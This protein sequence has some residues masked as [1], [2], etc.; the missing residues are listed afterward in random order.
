MELKKATDIVYFN[1]FDPRNV[2]ARSSTLAVV[3]RSPGRKVNV[4]KPTFDYGRRDQFAPS[5]FNLVE[6]GTIEDVESYVRQ[7]FQKKTAL[8]F[9][10][11]EEFIGK[12]P[13]TIKYIKTR[14]TQL[15]YVS[16]I[17]WR[18]LLR[19]TGH[20]LISRSNY[21]W[22]KS[23]NQEASGGMSI[24][25][26][27]PVAAYFGMGGEHVK[28]KKN[29]QGRIVKYKQ[30]MPD[31]RYREFSPRN[32]VHFYA[33]KKDGFAFGTPQIV[34]TK[35]DIRTLR[36]IEENVELLIY[37]TLFPIFQYQVGTELKPSGDIKLS[38]GTVISEVD[39]VREQIR[40]MP[41]EGGIVTPERHKLE[42]IGAEGKALKAREYLD[43]FKAR[44]FSGLGVSS[45]DMGEG[46]TANRSTSDTMSKT[47]I[48]SVKDFQSILEDFINSYILKE[49]LL[50]STFDFDV[51][52]PENIVSFKFKEIDIEQQMKKN[53]NAQVLYNGNVIDIDEARE[54][55]GKEPMTEDQEKK[56]FSNRVSIPELLVQI[57]GQL[58]IAQSR[59]SAASNQASNQNA[60]TN[61]HGKNT[62]PQKSKLD[63]FRVVDSY[64]GD[65][66]RSLKMDIS[67]HIKKEII[68]KNWINTLVGLSQDNIL[69][70]YRKIIS[71]EFLMGLRDS[72]LEADKMKDV[73]S[74]EFPIVDSNLTLYVNK[75]HRDIKGK[76][77][78]AID[79]NTALGRPNKEI[80]EEARKEI[81]TIRYRA[82]FI[83]KT[84]RARAYNYGK[85]LGLKNQGFEQIELELNKNCKICG[86]KPDIIDTDLLT[87]SD[88]PPYH[89]N[90][91]GKVKKGVAT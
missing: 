88:V 52:A 53:T 7:A 85:A 58:R 23:R 84:E 36:R 17:S 77:F 57:E 6:I 25:G 45:V 34:P 70:K 89:S 59:T 86:D 32:V 1:H 76:V 47:M 66:T 28:L 8:M 35:D 27:Q 4:R 67:K 60:P 40:D 63:S 56:M 39:F 11:G 38:D 30:E 68:N 31:G 65:M 5:E 2:D 74:V 82:D 49:L 46:G 19:S 61:Q 3:E 90:S 21:F 41:A 10:E 62:G 64:A 26:V 14:L 73:F 12:N 54:M 91:K 71:G 69:K 9:K 83:D 24:G 72:G 33:Y 48:D 87:L 20:A 78:L 50:E 42:F 81:D 29:K 55:A 51:L 43:Y 80:A 16:G 75:F 13:E 22:V 79:R 15:Q 18:Q 37:Q 44:V